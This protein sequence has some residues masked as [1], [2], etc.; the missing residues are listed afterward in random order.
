MGLSIALVVCSLLVVVVGQ[1]ML[2]NGQVRMAGITHNLALEESTHRQNVAA[3]S[4]LE[5]PYRI[6]STATNTLH[7]VH[8]P[9]LELPYVSLTTPLPTPT[10][11]PAP[12]TA[13]S[14]TTAA[15]K[16]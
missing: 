1:A 16:Q 4:V 6:V 9:V 11:T 2:A 8:A 14:S 7:M 5:Q 12:A 13:T 3:V 10:V 15:P